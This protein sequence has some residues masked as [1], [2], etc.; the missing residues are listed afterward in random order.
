[1]RKSQGTHWFARHE[2][3]HASDC[4]GR[5]SA[6]A[7]QFTGRNVIGLAFLWRG[8]WSVTVDHPAWQLLNELG[9][10]TAGRSGEKEAGR[11]LR[12]WVESVQGNGRLGDASLISGLCSARFHV[13]YISPAAANDCKTHCEN[14][15]D[16]PGGDR[17][18]TTSLMCRA[19]SEEAAP[20]PDWC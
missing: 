16:D 7:C 2:R 14:G 11:A 17:N 18:D 1:M 3:V 13:H 19:S 12:G 6:H 15:E 9:A 8:S 5:L 20:S 4:S 10:L